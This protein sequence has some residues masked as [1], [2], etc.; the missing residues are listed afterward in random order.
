VRL[1][2]V[3]FRGDVRVLGNQWKSAIDTGGK[4]PNFDIWCDGT[5]VWVETLRGDKAGHVFGVPMTAVDSIIPED[6]EEP[7]RRR[8]PAPT[9]PRRTKVP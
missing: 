6:A 7:K 9:K 4:E 3:L 8:A 5:W 1:K 2:K